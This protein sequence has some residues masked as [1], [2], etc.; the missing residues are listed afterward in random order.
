MKNILLFVIALLMFTLLAPVA[1]A[2]RLIKSIFFLRPDLAWFKRLALSIDQLG[3][4]LA[5]DLFNF[6]FIVN[7]ILYQFGDEDETVSSVIG[8][9][10][11]ANNLTLLGRCL[12]WI[13]H[14][15][16]HNHSVRSIERDEG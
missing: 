3:N 9:N 2:F 16:D 12:R 10:Y 1:I 5:D 15:L 11:V 4:V 7:P 14:Q 8:K 13:L 6:L